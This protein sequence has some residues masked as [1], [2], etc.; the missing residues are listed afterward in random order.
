MGYLWRSAN[1]QIDQLLWYV[2]TL[3]RPLR[4][5]FIVL[6]SVPAGLRAKEIAGLTWVMV[7]DADGDIGFRI[8]LKDKASKGRGGRV[9][10]INRQ[11][12]QKLEDLLTQ[13]RDEH[14][15]DISTSHV[16]T[17]ES[18]RKTTSQ[19]IVNMFASWYSD[20]GLVGCSSHSGRRTFVTNAAK[21]S[22]ASAGH[23]A[24]CRCSQGTRHSR[25][26]NATPTAMQKHAQGS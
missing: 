9:I 26:H 21:K 7:T 16:I 22:A 12:R 13:S 17:T 25:L 15:F 18:A 11:L 3:R 1:K 10:P 2:G 24:I 23:Y 19:S 8:H 6:L 20:V 14:G 4:N 5:E